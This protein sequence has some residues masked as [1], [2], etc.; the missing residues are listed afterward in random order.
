MNLLKLWMIFL[1]SG[2]GMVWLPASSAELNPAE[3]LGKQLF[4]EA[5]LSNP[6]GQSCASC[7]APEAAFSDPRKTLPVSAGANNGMFTSRNA[8]SVM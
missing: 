1:L 7:H 8:P 2:L 6:Q 4:F 5:R 3:Q